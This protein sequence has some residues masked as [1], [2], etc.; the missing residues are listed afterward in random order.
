MVNIITSCIK[1]TD[2]AAVQLQTTPYVHKF[3]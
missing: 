2:V 3:Y 1:T